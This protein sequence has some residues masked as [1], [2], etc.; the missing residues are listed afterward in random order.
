[1]TTA[2]GDV[3]SESDGGPGA[4]RDAAIADRDD[5]IADRGTWWTVVAGP[6]VVCLFSLLTVP[7]VLGTLDARLHSPLAAP[8]YA[9]FVAL[10]VVG[11]RVVPQF[12]F[13]LYW[14]PFLLCSYGVAVAGAGVGR[15]CLRGSDRLRGAARE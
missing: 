11:E 14:P 2:G 5:A 15:A 1:M 12:A 7:L 13:R 9:L 4:D 8:G 10:T 6:G 3:T